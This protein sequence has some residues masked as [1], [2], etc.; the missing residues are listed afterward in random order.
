MLQVSKIE[1][2]KSTSL[3]KS[4]K[5]AI[6]LIGGFEKFIK[7]GDVVFLKPNFNTADPFPASTDLEFLKIVVELVYDYG[8]KLVVVGDSCTYYQNTRKVMEKLGI[9]GLQNMEQSP[10]V[11][12]FEERNWI[13][14]EI[15]NGKFLK[16]V[17]IP[18]VLDE[19]DKLIL[20]PCLKTHFAAQYSGALKLSVGFMKPI[21]RVRLHLKNIQEKIAELNLVIHP[22]LIIMD[23]RK[24]F[25]NKG[26]TKGELREPGLI[27][28]S[29]N[30]VAIDIEGI[31][32]IQSY[33]GNSLRDIDPWELPQIKRAREI[34]ID[35]F[36]LS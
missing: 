10:K 8:A 12:V 24:C 30:R 34:G 7:I 26:P 6:D 31:K 28:A 5:K 33:K 23:A 27:L 21:E 11:Y 25:I 20:L 29:T 35:K 4:I 22:N 1:A 14:K 2:N 9:F 32:I 13:K 18:Q 3:K 17:S 19:V 16:K 36:S 15:K